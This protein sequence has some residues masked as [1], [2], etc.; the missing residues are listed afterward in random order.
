MKTGRYQ[1]AITIFKQADARGL[2]QNI[3]HTS[4]GLC[5]ESLGKKDEAKAEF[6]KAIDIAPKENYT[7]TAREHLGRLQ[8]GA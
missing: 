4:L 3:V 1:D 8:A 2:H 6:Q 5:Y 7:L